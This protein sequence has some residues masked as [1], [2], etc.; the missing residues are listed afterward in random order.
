MSGSYTE[1]LKVAQEAVRMAA[2]VCQSV[3]KAITTE[4]LAKK[5]KS[6]VTVADFASQAIVCRALQAAFPAD[7]VIGEEDSAELRTPEAAPFLANVKSELSHIGIDATDED[8]CGW[9]DRGGSHT[10]A[11][12]FWTLDP[13]DGTKGFLRGEQYA[14]SLALIV[15]GK[16]DVAL[17]GCPNLPLSGVEPGSSGTLLFAVRGHGAWQVPLDGGDPQ[18]IHCTTAETF[19]D[20]RLCE[21]VESGH[22]AHGLSARVADALGIE[23]EPVRLDSQAKYA[24][25][26]RG[27]A[28][29]YLRLPTRVGYREK[30]WDHAGGV[31]LVEEAGGT[32]TDVT[33]KPLEFTH[34]HQLEENLGVIVTNTRLHDSVVSNVVAAREAEEAEAK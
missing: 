14:I 20:A 5:D 24:V 3:Q 32:V 4:A 22:S 13:I 12:R 16:I 29:I 19:A 10:H 9:I 8:I 26:A 33:G 6:P 30:I 1:E 28:D 34:G 15:D 18:Q 27:D 11:P 21:S 25:V 2:R 31:L 17:L 7:P 23:N